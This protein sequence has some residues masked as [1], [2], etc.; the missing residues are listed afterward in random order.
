MAVEGSAAPGH[1]ESRLRGPGGEERK[2]ELLS[3]FLLPAS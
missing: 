2:E 3:L 1:H